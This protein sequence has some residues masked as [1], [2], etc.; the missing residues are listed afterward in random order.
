METSL[1]DGRESWWEKTYN[2]VA[3]MRAE[4][5]ASSKDVESVI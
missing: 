3:A 4:P 5:E 1:T 2:P